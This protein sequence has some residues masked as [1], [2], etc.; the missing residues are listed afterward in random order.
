MTH[1]VRLALV[2]GLIFSPL[3]GL[4]A[5]VITYE[6]YQ[7]HYPDRRRVMR[8]SAEAGVTT[9]VVFLLLSLIVGMLV[10]KVGQ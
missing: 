3:A 5:F 6:E 2:L 10:A 1:T 4:M 8:A 9:F 7:H